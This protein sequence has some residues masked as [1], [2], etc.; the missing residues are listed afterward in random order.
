MQVSDHVALEPL[1]DEWM[2]IHASPYVEI[3]YFYWLKLMSRSNRSY[4]SR[5]G[6]QKLENFFPDQT[7]WGPPKR[8]LRNGKQCRECESSGLICG[9]NRYRF[10]GAILWNGFSAAAVRRW[11]LSERLCVIDIPDVFCNKSE[12]MVD[13]RFL[14][15]DFGAEW[16]VL[17]HMI[18]LWE[19]GVY[20]R[21]KWWCSIDSF[22]S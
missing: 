1:H 3:I 2:E 8:T 14:I 13:G 6:H 17:I 4:E 22:E 7:G 12:L 9:K 19:R 15:A 20:M 18:S 11:L 16:S 5:V 21:C 10:L